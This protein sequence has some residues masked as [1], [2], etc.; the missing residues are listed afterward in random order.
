MPSLMLPF[1]LTKLNLDKMKFLR[2]PLVK[3][4]RNEALFA[5]VDG[6]TVLEKTERE[7]NEAVDAGVDRIGIEN[8]LILTAPTRK[9]KT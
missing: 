8:V 2:P 3:C 6:K 4:E 9:Y 5:A 1:F 7:Q